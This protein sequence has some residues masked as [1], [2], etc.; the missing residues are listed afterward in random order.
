MNCD[1]TSNNKYFDCPAIMSDGRIFTDYRQAYV[2]NDQIKLKNKQFNNYSY[3]QFLINNGDN[4]MKA[5]ND[6]INTKAG[7]PSCIPIHTPHKVVCTTNSV[8]SLCRINDMNGIGTRYVSERDA[9]K[10]VEFYEPGVQTFASVAA[11]TVESE[12][13]MNGLNPMNPA[14]CG[15]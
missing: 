12:R 1:K 5:N 2:I 11:P 15:N 10:K 9:N 7:C 13:V 3:R 6:Y 8:N 4:L 14:Y